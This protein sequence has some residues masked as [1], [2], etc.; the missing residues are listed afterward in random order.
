MELHVEDDLVK[1]I[2][3][4]RRRSRELDIVHAWSFYFLFPPGSLIFRLIRETGNYVGHAITRHDYSR[5]RHRNRGDRLLKYKISLYFPFSK[6]LNCI[7]ITKIEIYADERLRNGFLEPKY[8]ITNLRSR[9]L[10]L[11]FRYID[12]ILR[13]PKFELLLT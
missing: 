10:Q 11:F 9:I 12:F 13:F 5:L 1:S 4:P 7:C 8:E 2:R 3:H 6:N